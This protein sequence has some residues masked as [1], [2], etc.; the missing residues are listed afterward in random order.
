[1]NWQDLL[2]KLY[3]KD[4]EAVFMVGSRVPD[5]NI[6]RLFHSTSQARENFVDFKNSKV[7]VLLER[8]DAASTREERISLARQIQQ[9]IYIEQPYTFLTEPRFTFYAVRPGIS[10]RGDSLP[11]DV[12]LQHWKRK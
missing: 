11:Y 2:N 1:M 6:F 3:L 4:Y 12:G 5:E 9:L 8:H 10:R 7:D